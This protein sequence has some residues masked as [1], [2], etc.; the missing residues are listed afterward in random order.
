M[1]NSPLVT[2][3]RPPALLQAAHGGRT[4]ML[5]AVI[6][7]MACVVLALVELP[8]A[9]C[10]VGVENQGIQVAFLEKL[11]DHELMTNGVLVARTLGAYPCFFFHLCA[12]VLAATRVDFA[13][14]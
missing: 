4:P 14:L 11:R 8:W 1:S 7:A 9:G 2:T 12:K 13:T 10:Q 6:W 5:Q 3:P